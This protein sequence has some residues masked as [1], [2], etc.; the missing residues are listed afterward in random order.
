MQTLES[1]GQTQLHPHPNEFDHKRIE[2]ALETRERYRYV[3]P[4]VLPASGGYRIES[5][6][7]SRNVDPQGGVIDVAW[8]E[9]Q[10]DTHGWR[11]YNKNH[12]AGC[13]EVESTHG[14]LS[15]ALKKLAADPERKFWQ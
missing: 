14:R 9:Y 15:D 8:I 1:Q 10:A 6:C 4:R 7:C 13:W 11:L 12:V 5:P 3:S 2:R